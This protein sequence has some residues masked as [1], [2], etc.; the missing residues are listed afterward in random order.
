MQTT[1]NPSAG[2]RTMLPIIATL[3]T[4][5]FLNDTR[6][7]VIAAS[8]PLIKADLALS[9]TQIGF[10]SLFYQLASSVFQTV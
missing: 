6:Q 3:A 4:L 9:F 7:S 10:I 8:Y 2:F 1:Y 5:H